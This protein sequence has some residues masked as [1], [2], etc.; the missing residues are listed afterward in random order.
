MK[1]CRVVSND[2]DNAARYPQRGRLEPTAGKGSLA[3]P[4]DV[5][6]TT[7][8]SVRQQSQKSTRTQKSG[9]YRVSIRKP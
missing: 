7:L 5:V 4:V 8:L 9:H 3:G 1:K 6:R 2:L